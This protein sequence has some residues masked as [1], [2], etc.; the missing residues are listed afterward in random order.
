MFHVAPS[1]MRLKANFVEDVCD[2]GVVSS[3]GNEHWYVS[4]D[5]GDTSSSPSFFTW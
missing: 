2:V 3:S 1:V 4:L 5:K